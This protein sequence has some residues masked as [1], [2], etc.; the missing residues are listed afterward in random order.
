MTHPRD[1]NYL[2]GGGIM[3]RRRTMTE[4]RDIIRRL[5]QS[6]SIRSIQK[7]TGFHRKIIRKIKSLAEEEG[8]LT[9][10]SELP[11]EVI[12]K[13][14][15]S[16]NAQKNE[17]PLDDYKNEIKEYLDKEYSFVV[18]HKLIGRKFSCSESTIRRYIHKNFKN[19][20]ITT[21]IRK[22]IAGEI[23]EV[24][25]GYLGLTFDPITRRNKKTYIFSGRLRHSRDA[26]REIVFNQKQNTFFDCHIHAFEY[27]EGVP[28][29]VVPDNLKA[30]VIKASFENPLINRVYQKLAEHYGFLISPCLPR[31]PNHKGGV[32]NDIKYVKKNFWPLF[33]EDQKSKGYIN[34]D[35]N[36]LKDA[37]KLWNA[38]TARIR[39]VHGIGRSPEEMFESEE[40]AALK[41]LPM[42]R[43]DNLQW[44]M[45]IKVQQTW[46]VQFDNAY[47]SVPYKYIGEKVNIL[48]SSKSVYIFFNYKQ[49]ALHSRAEKRW[50]HMESKDHAPPNVE[51]YMQT[52]RDSIKRWAS[53]IGPSVCR[54]VEEILLHKTID[55]LRPARA[56]IGLRKKYGAV[57]LEAACKRALTYDTAEYF[58]VKSILVKG[59]DKLDINEPVDKMGQQLFTFAR[60]YGYFDLEQHEEKESINERLNFT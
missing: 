20:P 7:E 9:I 41:P 32:E 23:M 56:V 8:W 19:V 50:A 26:Y 51:L 12:L 49:I 35:T 16:N 11:D 24:D 55:G 38:R 15:L 25:F 6:Q 42:T 14:V 43:W 54:V 57:R 59:L 18:I 29:K 44:S 45:N 36:E 3:P 31:K 28:E 39:K 40:K 4:Y 37:L 5:K 47:Y 48:A 60:K 13:Q 1:Y 21:M 52:T 33:K 22:T 34:L 58:S 2:K 30:A 27:F 10:E 46:R 53:N 17:H